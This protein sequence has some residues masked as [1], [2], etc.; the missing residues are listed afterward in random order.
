MKKKYVA[1][2][3][4]ESEIAKIKFHAIKNGLSVSGQ[5]GEIVCD[6]LTNGDISN[7][8]LQ[9]KLSAE[10]AHAVLSISELI[11]KKDTQPEQM[12]LLKREKAQTINKT[13]VITANK[14][15]CINE[16]YRKKFGLFEGMYTSENHVP[17]GDI[18]PKAHNWT[19]IAQYRSWADFHGRQYESDVTLRLKAEL[20]SKG[21]N[22]YNGN[23]K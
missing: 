14:L 20:H 11:G 4:S 22:E 19:C 10:I 17:S 6:Y 15:Q 8:Q 12:P 18:N 23:N 13:G 21:K 7:L 16:E 9:Q 5:A 1:I 2:R 3:L